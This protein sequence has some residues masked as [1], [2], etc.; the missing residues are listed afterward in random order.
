MNKRKESRHVSVLMSVYGEEEDWLR[1]AVDSILTQTY[2]NFEF[3][4]TLDK[5]ENELLW[6]VLKEY[7]RKDT[8]IVLSR[9]EQNM[10]LAAT[11]NKAIGMSRGDYIVRMDADD[12]SV[13]KRIEILIEFMESHQEI[14]VS[15]SWMKSFGG[16]FLNNRIAKYPAKHD[17]LEIKSLYNT[18]I[19]H[20]PCIIR[21]T[22]I[23]KFSPLYNE[24]CCRTQDY[25]LWSR[26]MHNKVKFAT[27]PKVLYLV[28]G[29]N[30]LGPLPI[31]YQVIHN[32]VARNNIQ[33]VLNSYS[34]LLPDKIAKGDVKE[35][36]KVLRS[37]KG[38]RKQKKQLAV[39]LF[40]YYL[41]LELSLIKRIGLFLSSCDFSRCSFYLPLKLTLR[42]ILPGD[43]I[44]SVNNRCT[45]ASMSIF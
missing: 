20:A 8:R 42:I 39:I 40:V 41:S 44:L 31:P 45:D 15:S 14:G 9:N 16:T 22:V 43:S 33:Q 17:D 1:K 18:P 29:S 38:D 19:A 10:G 7:E 5:P 23:D 11:L 3:I 36:S 4:I 28:R 26:L 6:G 34:I 35:L 13:P 24:K 37:H 27:I 32:Q 12:I 21:R 2:S 25:E 30:G